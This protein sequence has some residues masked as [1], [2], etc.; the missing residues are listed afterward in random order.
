LIWRIFQ[1]SFKYCQE[2][3]SPTTQNSLTSP[4]TTT[5]RLTAKQDEALGLNENIEMAFNLDMNATV[6]VKSE[7]ATA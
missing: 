5:L 3:I 4:P 6:I 2:T 1:T 7:I